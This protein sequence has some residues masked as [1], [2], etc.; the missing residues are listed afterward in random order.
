MPNISW[1]RGRKM[2]RRCGLILLRAGRAPWALAELTSG[3]VFEFCPL[4]PGR[5]VELQG[6]R[7]ALMRC[8]TW[9]SRMACGCAR[10]ER[11]C[12]FRG[13]GGDGRGVG[14]GPRAD[15]FFAR[16]ACATS[17]LRNRG[18]TCARG[19]PAACRPGG[20]PA[21]GADP[22]PASHAAAILARPG[23]STLRRCSHAFLRAMRS[24]KTGTS[25]KQKERGLGNKRMPH[26]LTRYGWNATMMMS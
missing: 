23:S 7:C 24:V 8:L 14:A 26:R 19:W 22:L 13:Y 15:L 1:K 11:F 2:G 18:T 20:R 5:E 10:R 3:G 21:P 17:R 4:E 12:L 6:W 16:R 25:H 9:W